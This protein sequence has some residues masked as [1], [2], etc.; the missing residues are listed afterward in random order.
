MADA[1]ERWVVGGQDGYPVGNPILIV[2]AV[3]GALLLI[4]IDPLTG[5]DAPPERA[6]HS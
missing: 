3:T 4:T 6:L 5:R 1:V 2:Q